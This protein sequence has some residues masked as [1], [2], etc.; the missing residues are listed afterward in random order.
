MLV[1]DLI[2]V[3]DSEESR[4]NVLELEEVR[5]ESYLEGFIGILNYGF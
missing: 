5:V 4:E 1:N 2:Y 3:L